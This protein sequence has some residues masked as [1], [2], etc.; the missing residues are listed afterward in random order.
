MTSANQG[1]RTVPLEGDYGLP[2]RR[3]RGEVDWTRHVH[4]AEAAGARLHYLDYGDPGYGQP[5]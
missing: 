5:A 3:P 1:W 4:A 2:G